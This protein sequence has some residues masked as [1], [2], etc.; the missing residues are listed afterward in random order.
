M[1]KNS[2]NP[3]SPRNLADL[4]HTVEET[5]HQ[6]V[7]AQGLD[8]RVAILR[9]WQVDRLKRTY[10]DLLMHPRYKPACEFF[11]NDIYAARDF[12]QR[13]HDIRRLH[14][15]LRKWLPEFMVRPLRQAIELHDLT[16]RLD[17]QL[18]AVMIAELGLTDTVTEEM[19]AEAYRRCDNYKVRVRQIK[20][21]VAT[22]N[23][24]ETLVNIPFSGSAMRLGRG[25]AERAG[26]GDLM[27]F[28]ER[29]Y[30]A[31]KHMHGA[32]HFLGTISRR[33]RRILDRIYAKDP[34]PF[35]L[36]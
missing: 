16:E 5:P 14:D 11:I 6:D 34:N 13:N 23:G 8:P 22:G 25:P 17:T 12:T 24:V 36:S 1:T 7:P 10:H 3:K 31:F 20:W 9:D 15:A 2:S 19:Y 26:W 4:L 18:L 21:I 27:S 30:A 28:L 29:G 32:K 35:A 33:E